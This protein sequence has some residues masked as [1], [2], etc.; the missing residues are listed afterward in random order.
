MALVSL[1]LLSR[2]KIYQLVKVV[3]FKHGPVLVAWQ[4]WSVADR[5]P[6][7]SKFDSAATR[8][9]LILEIAA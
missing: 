9:L 2:L 7:T 5:L 8:L 1:E 3:Q 6:P 4:W